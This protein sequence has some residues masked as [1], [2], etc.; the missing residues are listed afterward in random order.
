M[1]AE[2]PVSE[3]T[4]SLEHL[5]DDDLWTV[6]QEG[7]LVALDV[8]Y[9][10]Y[11]VQAYSLAYKILANRDEAEDVTQEVFVTLWQ[12]NSYQPSRGSFKSFLMT[13]VRSRSIDRIRRRGSRH[14]FLQRWQRASSM[15]QH[16][17]LPL[18]EVSHNEQAQLVQEALSSLSTK[19]R[20]VLEIAYYKGASQSQIA[21]QLNIPLG[22]VKSRSRKALKKLRQRLHFLE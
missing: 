9:G 1:A 5:S 15:H 2:F 16:T 20:E 13:L 7:N 14:R 17:P 18:E 6:L 21:K 22:T 19:E 8:L 4:T 11:S 3:K 12:K 10:R